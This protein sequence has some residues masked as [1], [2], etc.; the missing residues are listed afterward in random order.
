M[1]IFR[2]LIT[3]ESLNQDKTYELV[4]LQISDCTAGVPTAAV[5]I[6]YKDQIWK[7][8]S[9]WWWNNGC[10]FETIDN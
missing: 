7:R 10:N 1:M 2:M 5:A 4:G 3:D 9:Y 6:K 8:C